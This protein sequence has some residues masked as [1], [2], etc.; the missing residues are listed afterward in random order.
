MERLGIIL[1]NAI[2]EI[3][4]AAPLGSLFVEEGASDPLKWKRPTEVRAS[5]AALP[6]RQT[7]RVRRRTRRVARR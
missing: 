2:E 7:K 5:V 6:R 1:A 4:H 3:L